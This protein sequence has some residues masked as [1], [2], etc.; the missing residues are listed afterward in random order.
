MQWHTTAISGGDQI[1]RLNCGTTWF[2]R[3]D[4][5]GVLPPGDG[6]MNRGTVCLRSQCYIC[7]YKYI[8]VYVFIEHII[9]IYY[10]IILIFTPK[11]FS[12]LYFLQRRD[13]IYITVKIRFNLI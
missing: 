6:L 12:L 9:T 8:R 4:G 2:E 10:H 11:S 1:T 7:T 3:R 13:C 5:S